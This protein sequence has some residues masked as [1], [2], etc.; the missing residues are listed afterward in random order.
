M[1]TLCQVLL[2]A[3]RGVSRADSAPA[4]REPS[5]VEKV[6]KRKQI[7]GLR[8]VICAVMDIQKCCDGIIW[9]SPLNGGG[10]GKPRNV[11]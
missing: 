5:L 9:G 8:A 2:R 3:E 1:H 7:K 10:W 4:L 11:A 6:I